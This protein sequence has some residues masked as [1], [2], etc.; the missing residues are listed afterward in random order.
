MA[1]NFFAA[2]KP[3]EPAGKPAP[4]TITSDIGDCLKNSM[5]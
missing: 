4:N 3:G 1:L 5:G 2:C